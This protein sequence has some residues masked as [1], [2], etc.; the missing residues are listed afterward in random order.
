MKKILSLTF[1]MLLISSFNVM[2]EKCKYPCMGGRVI[3]GGTIPWENCD[4]ISNC[5]NYCGKNGLVCLADQ[6]NAG[7]I[8][9]K[10]PNVGF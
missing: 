5:V 2:A 7:S 10:R 3:T 1:V 8:P 6:Y 4:D 9:V